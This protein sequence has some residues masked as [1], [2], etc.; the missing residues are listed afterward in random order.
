MKS[1]DAVPPLIGSMGK[2]TSHKHLAV[3]LAEQ[4]A[5]DHGP[6]RILVADVVPGFKGRVGGAVAIE[7]DD[8]A[9]R[10]PG[11]LDLPVGKGCQG[12][13]LMV[14]CDPAP[15]AGSKDT[16]RDPSV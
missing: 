9:V 1:R 8:A 6:E 13:Q 4:L 16:S 11:D 15:A 12:D 14:N 2:F 10:V 7:P 5:G 3:R